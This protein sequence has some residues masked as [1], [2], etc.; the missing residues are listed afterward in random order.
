LYEDESRHAEALKAYQEAQKLKKNSVYEAAI[1]RMKAI[2]SSKTRVK[3]EN[4]Q[5]VSILH[6]VSLCVFICSA[7]GES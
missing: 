6:R 2:T 1:E 3:Y 5:R 4:P 7:S